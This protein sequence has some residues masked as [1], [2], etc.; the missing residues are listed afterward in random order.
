MNIPG[1]QSIYK[2]QRNSAAES[3]CQ[4]KLKIYK[5]TDP[6]GIKKEMIKINE[7]CL[8]KTVKNANFT[9]N[10]KTTKD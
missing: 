6:L 4:S 10:R 9:T 1:G 2:T 7:R 5:N 3:P 8:N